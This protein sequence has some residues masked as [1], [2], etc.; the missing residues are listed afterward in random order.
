MKSPDQSFRPVGIKFNPN[1]KVM[2]IASIGD[3]SVIK[4]TPNGALLPMPTQWPYLHSGIIWK[5]TYQ[6]P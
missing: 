3:Y 6:P 1:G 4:I 5:V 2:Y